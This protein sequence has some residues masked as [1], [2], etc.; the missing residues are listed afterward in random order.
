MSGLYFED[1]PIGR[2]FAPDERI[3]LD[4]DSILEFARQYD[5]QPFHTDPEG[6]AAGPFGGLIASGW[7]TMA[8]TMGLIVR[9]MPIEGGMVGRQV[10]LGWP[11]PVRPGD[12]LGITIEVTEARP[13][14]SNPARGSVTLR[15]LTLNQ[16]GEVVQELTAHVMAPRRAE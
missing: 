8:L 3:A 14:R 16:H 1:L 9:N 15:V 7:Q 10:E 2:R 6:A 4:Q 5:P 12:T 11:R 13:S